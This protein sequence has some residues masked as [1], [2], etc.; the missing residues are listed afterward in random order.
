M[1]QNQASK[2]TK[3]CKLSD[4][5]SKNFKIVFITS[6]KEKTKN[7]DD[8]GLFSVKSEF[9]SDELQNKIVG[10]FKRIGFQVVEFF[11]EEDFIAF[12]IKLSSEDRKKLIV[13]NSAQKGTNIGRKS[14]I[15]SFCDLYNIEYVGSNP[16]VVSL[17]RDKYKC[18]NILEQ[19]NIPTPK[20]WIYNNKYG[21]L[22]GSPEKFNG[23]LIIKPNYESSSIGIDKKCIGEYSSMFSQKI[24]EYSIIFKQDIIVEEFISGY[25]VE[26]PI[27]CTQ[28][29]ITF[30]PV[31]IEKNGEK[32][33]GDQILDYETRAKNYYS[34][35]NFDDY[36]EALSKQL[37]ETAKKTVLLLNIQ[38]F[39]RVDFRIKKNGDFY[40]TDVST[41]P[42]YTEHSSFYV[43]FK[44]LQFQYDHMIKSL[45][46]TVYERVS[47][48]EINFNA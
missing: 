12:A 44:S 34:L 30:F 32:L 19:N 26:T 6:H 13:I 14:L 36:D 43:P 3:L 9:Y 15:P 41:N 4:E 17:C 23:R 1:Y 28:Q 2:I 29:P 5:L 22:N 39:G 48:A 33:I 18:G 46:A 16:F 21:W 25:E 11:N 40:V 24:H 42:H 47:H 27:I 31:G 45:I 37:I 20:A 35:Y 38:G 10:S 8:Y 7:T